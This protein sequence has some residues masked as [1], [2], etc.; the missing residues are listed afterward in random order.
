MAQNEQQVRWVGPALRELRALPEAV[1]VVAGFALY[2]A[3]QGDKHVDAKPLKG[4]PGASV[5]E[6]AVGERGN[7][8]RVV[9]TTGFRGVIYVLCAFQKKAQAGRK[10]PNRR[11]ELIQSR[12]RT[13][14]EHYRQ[15]PI[16]GR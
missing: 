15:K 12:L 13:A 8:Y 11:M 3:Q 7:T 16:R 4:F 6:V 14:E 1:R 10:T 5:L 2:Q 9:Y